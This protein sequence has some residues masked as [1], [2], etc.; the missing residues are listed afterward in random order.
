MTGGE[1]L[2]VG[3]GP[4]GR[5]PTLTTRETANPD[6][7]VGQE[8]LRLRRGKSMGVFV[9]A[10]AC[11]CVLVRVCVYVCT[12]KCVYMC[13]CVHVSACACMRVCV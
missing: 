11:I 7:K 9:C 5:A 3:S 8:I 13:V 4:S 10:Y 1:G 12:H 6:C 2:P